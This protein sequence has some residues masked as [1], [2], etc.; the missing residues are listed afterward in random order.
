MVIVSHK[1][2][3]KKKFTY[4]LSDK[5]HAFGANAAGGQEVIFPIEISSRISRC[6]CF[7]MFMNAQIGQTEKTQGDLSCTEVCCS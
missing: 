5:T 6:L 4:H 2:V 7:A 3:C 1:D